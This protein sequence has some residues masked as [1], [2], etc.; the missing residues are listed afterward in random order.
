M[1][2]WYMVFNEDAHGNKDIPFYFLRKF[3]A[4]FI[5]GKHVNY[6]DILEFQGVGHGIPHDMKGRIMIQTV[7]D[8]L[9]AHQTP[10][11]YICLHDL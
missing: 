6:F 2:S 1:D 10:L 11:L 5:F 8:D 3:Y 9:C 7:C 4:E